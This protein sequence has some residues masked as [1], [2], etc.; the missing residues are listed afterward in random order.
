MIPSSPGRVADTRPASFLGSSLGLAAA[1][2]VGPPLRA[3]P[4]GPQ[5]PGFA[6]FHGLDARREVL[7]FLL[8]LALPLAGGVLAA[9]RARAPARCGESVA[10]ASG[11]GS[12]PA[13]SLATVCAHAIALWLFVLAGFPSRSPLPS[14]ALAVVASAALALAL[15]A[16]SLRRGALCLGA[17]GPVLVLAF[18]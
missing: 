12:T 10:E 13:V 16:G 7:L 11:D 17:A 18:V 5:P 1:A 15:G 4:A 14:L 9:R 6:A 3:L 2:I 8:T